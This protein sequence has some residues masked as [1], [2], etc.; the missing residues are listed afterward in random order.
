MNPVRRSTPSFAGPNQ[1]GMAERPRN[2]VQ[3][4]SPGAA[5]WRGIPRKPAACILEVR[6]TVTMSEPKKSFNVSYVEQQAQ[7]V[8]E[9]LSGNR[10]S[11]LFE[12]AIEAGFLTALAN[13]REDEA[14]RE[15]L[16]KAVEILSA[17]LVIEWEVEPLVEAIS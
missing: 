14:E 2:S 6:E 7:T 4:L 11:A 8:R 9:Q 16:I 1:R 3:D 15:A 17:G 13:G 5:C 12:A 10:Q